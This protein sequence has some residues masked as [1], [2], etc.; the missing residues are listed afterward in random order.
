MKTILTGKTKYFWKGVI[1][2]A[3][4]LIISLHL[5]YQHRYAFL[6]LI[7]VQP[8][9][10]CN[11]II[12]GDQSDTNKKNLFLE[13]YLS[14]GGNIN[15]NVQI[16]EGI[17]NEYLQVEDSGSL[18]HCAIA[19]GNVKLVRD[20]LELGANPNTTSYKKTTRFIEV[21]GE[22]FHKL[23]TETLTPLK[24]IRIELAKPK[25]NKSVVHILEHE[26]KIQNLEI[27]HYLVKYGAK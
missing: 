5:I 12:K 13:D 7:G 14:H 24:R 20:L 6:K 17:D 3:V 26:K 23:E 19:Y 1:V 9:D 25:Q 10:L 21:G 4:S 16:L 22:G 8:P 18:L 2:A 27:E 15:T 11:L